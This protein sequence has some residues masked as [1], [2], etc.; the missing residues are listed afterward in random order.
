MPRAVTPRQLLW[1]LVASIQYMIVIYFLYIFFATT[2][3]VSICCIQCSDNVTFLESRSKIER[4]FV[5]TSIILSLHN[6]SN[7]P[8]P[9]TQTRARPSPYFLVFIFFFFFCFLVCVL[10]FF[11]CFFRDKYLRFPTLGP[12]TFLTKVAPVFAVIKWQKDR[13][14]P[15]TRSNSYLITACKG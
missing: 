2:R 6:C 7:P 11:C 1:S 9:P 5:S 15:L 12:K 4:W 14:N 13:I 3:F 10:L 8:P